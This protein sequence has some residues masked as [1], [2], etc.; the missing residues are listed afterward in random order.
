MSKVIR[1]GAL[2]GGV[3]GLVLALVLRVLGERSID[4]AVQLEAA[5]HPVGAHTEMF[6]RGTQQAGGMIGALLYGVFVGVVLSLVVAAV[7]HRL[8][9]IS[10]WHNVMTIA[11]AA[12]VTVYL[13][14]FLKYPA[15][16]PGVG[17]PA[18]IGRRTALYLV[19]LAWSVVSTFAA[20][21]LSRFLRLR[22]V[23]DQARVPTV[24]GAY[25]A[26]ITFAF[27]VLS[28]SPDQ[29]AVPAVLLWRFRLS[30]V[31][32]AAAFWVTTGLA[33]GWLLERAPRT[34]RSG[35][36]EELELVRG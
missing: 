10:D 32:G 16:P 7:R 36:A 35:D 13:V 23:P 24:L 30:S 11:V 14:P 34:E 27:V 20:W 26:L 3:G 29:V 22:G 28:G 9:A 33:L 31:C 12:F 8:G 6:S 5:R 1:N 19:V 25:V 4:K 18:T 15:N 21:R 17:D 2:A